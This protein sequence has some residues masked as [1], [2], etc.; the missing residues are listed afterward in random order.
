AG[1]STHNEA[2]TI[3]EE[4][5]TPYEHQYQ[6]EVEKQFEY[7]ES[8]IGALQNDGRVV[9]GT[10]NWGR[11]PFILTMERIEATDDIPKDLILC[12][13]CNSKSSDPHWRCSFTV[14]VQCKLQ[15]QHLGLGEDNWELAEKNITATR[16]NNRMIIDLLR[17]PTEPT[18]VDTVTLKIKIKMNSWAGNYPALIKSFTNKTDITD[19][20]L[21]VEGRH[22]YVSRAILALNSSF[23]HTLFYDKRFPD[24][25]KEEHALPDI[26]FDDMVIF[27]GLI[28]PNVTFESHKCISSMDTIEAMLMLAERFGCDSVTS[29]MEKYLL[30]EMKGDIEGFTFGRRLLLSDRFRLST[31][32]SQLMKELQSDNGMRELSESEEYNELSESLRASILDV[33]MKQIRDAPSIYNGIQPVSIKIRNEGRIPLSRPFSQASA[34]SAS[35]FAADVDRLTSEAA[36]FAVSNSQSD[37]LDRALRSLR[38]LIRTDYDQISYASRIFLHSAVLNLLNSSHKSVSMNDLNSRIDTVIRQVDIARSIHRSDPNGSPR[39]RMRLRDYV[40]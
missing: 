9:L 10:M 40:L 22:L 20:T 5:A 13:N 6:T 11:V 1:T 28:Y 23:F 21:I 27:L 19:A 32:C 37:R 15:G 33:K 31:P 24:A 29:L 36:N 38:D 2:T 39:K 4:E 12:V 14:S 17:Y 26:S 34:A 7:E 16:N 25:S 30:E 8:L 18:L 35:S 3:A